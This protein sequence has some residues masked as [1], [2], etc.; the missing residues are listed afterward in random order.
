[1]SNADFDVV[2]G[3]P[4][5]PGKPP[6]APDRRAPADPVTP[7]ALPD[8]GA[9]QRADPPPRAGAATGVP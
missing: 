5:P 1:M 2:T 8:A 7:A 4:A 9:P 6:A 3:P